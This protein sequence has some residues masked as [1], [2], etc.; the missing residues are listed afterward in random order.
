MSKDLQRKHR[1]VV[2]PLLEWHGSGTNT[3]LQ[4]LNLL[5]MIAAST[6]ATVTGVVNMAAGRGG[7][8]QISLKAGDWAPDFS[9]PGS[10]GSPYRLS[11]FRGRQA[12][13]L[14]WFPKAFTG[15]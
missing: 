10:D 4:F 2:M 3:Q 8:A 9:L 6:T 13:V 7:G 15:G 12:V 11:D 1:T 14:A 5:R